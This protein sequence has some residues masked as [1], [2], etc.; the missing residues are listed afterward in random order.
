[1]ADRTEDDTIYFA[2]LTIGKTNS[3]QGIFLFNSK[4][5]EAW[6]LQG[7]QI[8]HLEKAKDILINLPV[9]LTK[10]GSGS[11]DALSL[12][13]VLDPLVSELFA[14]AN[15]LDLSSRLT[16]PHTMNRTARDSFVSYEFPSGTGINANS[17]DFVS[18]C[19]LLR[20][21]FAKGNEV[22]AGNTLR[23]C[24]LTL[25]KVTRF[26]ITAPTDR[27]RRTL[28]ELLEQANRIVGM[29]TVFEEIAVPLKL[30]DIEEEKKEANDNNDDDDDDDDD[31]DSE[32]DD[33]TKK[34]YEGESNPKRP[35]WVIP[36]QRRQKIA[37]YLTNNKLRRDYEELLKKHDERMWSRKKRK[38]TDK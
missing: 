30:K 2:S 35:I 16:F 11:R 4:H 14:L 9:L 10:I 23:S 33:S 12:K 24:G 29:I 32:D 15:S 6:S 20:D 5:G 21:G 22:N 37:R 31:D 27:E 17:E 19:I 36:N 8:W 28:D 25:S 13:S 18:R 34:G 1:M 38:R 26:S 3:I 7:S